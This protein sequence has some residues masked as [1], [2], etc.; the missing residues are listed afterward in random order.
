MAKKSEFT[1]VRNTPNRRR[2]KKGGLHIR[3]KL[4]PKHNRRVK[5]CFG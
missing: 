4:G 5:Q 2:H 1:L 3:K